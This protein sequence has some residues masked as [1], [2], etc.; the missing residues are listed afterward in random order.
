M[1]LQQMEEYL[2]YLNGIPKFESEKF[3]F[4][5]HKFRLRLIH[6][7]HSCIGDIA[8]RKVRFECSKCNKGLNMDYNY[9]ATLE[10]TFNYISI[11]SRLDL[12]TS[13]LSKLEETMYN[14]SEYKALKIIQD[15]NY[16]VAE[17]KEIINNRH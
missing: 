3:K 10:N 14:T 7:D 13:R 1:L 12:M 2:L 5:L 6:C 15:A 9:W 8:S 11:M 17:I 4:I 16:E